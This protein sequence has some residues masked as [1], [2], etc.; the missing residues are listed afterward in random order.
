[1][2]YTPYPYQQ[3]ATEHIIRYGGSG[4]FMEMGLGKT[5]S[6]LT[7]IDQLM[8]QEFEISK[9]LVIAPKRVAEDVWTTEAQKWDHL[10]H[11]KISLVLGTEK[12]R[13]QA[14]RAKADIYVINRENVVWLT[15]HYCTG[16]P[17]D[18]MVVDE[19][20]SFK[21]A[22]TR[23]FK[24][25]RE[26]RPLVR[27]V[28]GLTGTPAPNGLLDLWSQ[29]YLLDR[30]ER[31][32]DNLTGYRAKYFTK[33]YT[34]FG[35]YEVMK[36]TT[37][38]LL[39][40]DFYE[41]LIY[42]KIG[43]I[44][45]SMKTSDYLQ[46]PERINRYVNIRLPEKIQQKYDDFEEEQILAIADAEEIT[47]INAGALTTKLLQF[48]NGAVYADDKSWH[49]MH[50]EKLDALEEII[51]TANGQPVL[52]FYSYK[53]DLERILKR[54]K[55]Y[56]PRILKNAGDIRDWNH[57]K[58]SVLLAHPGSAGHGLNLQEGGSI[59]VWFG[60]TW[61]LELYQQAIARLHRLGQVRNVIIHH[62][63]AMGT[64]DEKVIKSLDSKANGQEML[65]KAVKAM[66]QKYKTA[67]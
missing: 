56:Q 64:M 48:A 4:L 47:A 54:L 25:L 30:G 62:L 11:L 57:G 29:V 27:R 13:L 26:V 16:F 63:V 32:G 43:D 66:I 19:L 44:C 36:N 10:K 14:L 21:S 8:Y 41:K 38:S 33:S 46:L 2:K 55:D 40:K 39:G 65:M 35:G 18:M 24:A 49:E 67:A 31:L 37:D 23:R 42:D 20:S 3:H 34:M 52:V 17:Y 45:I 15:A 51:D 60:L 1:M 28:V 53:H 50:K 12:Q 7:A 22:D 6:T 58:I 5:V 9:V 61:S 59:I